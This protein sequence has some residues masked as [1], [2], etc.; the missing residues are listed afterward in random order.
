MDARGGQFESAASHLALVEDNQD[1]EVWLVRTE[2]ALWTGRP[3]DAAA[4]ARLGLSVPNDP[5][6]E[7][8]FRSWLLRL[9]VR[10]EADRAEIAR[11][12]RRSADE[13][14]AVE[15]AA[16][17]TKAMIDLTKGPWRYED[18]YGGE[19]SPSAAVTE[20]EHARAAGRHDPAAW[21]TA[22][23]AWDA[24]GRPAEVAYARWREGEAI[25]GSSGPRAEARGALVEAAS[26]ARELGAEPLVRDI[27]RLAARARLTQPAGTTIP[28]TAV[29]NGS[30]GS[31]APGSGADLTRR[32]R[33][34]LSLLAEGR[35]NRQIAGALF[36]SESTAGVHV[37]HILGKLEVAGRTEA[38]SAAHRLG[39]VG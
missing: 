9:L 34:V 5:L 38:V 28:G 36:I 30:P 29:P 13:Y 20:A 21:A 6:D 22:A 23:V 1:P 10:A 37:S 12:R 7:Q 8:S 25:L 11:R 39:L 31:G 14:A 2:F 27:E 3:D 33:E 32:E 19:L 24:L 35:T 17:A 4:L 26:I 16:D 18:A 15:R